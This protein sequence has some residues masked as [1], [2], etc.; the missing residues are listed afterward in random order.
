M[1][2]PFRTKLKPP[3]KVTHNTLFQSLYLTI[4]FFVSNDLLSYASACAFGFLFSFIPVV[5]LILVVLLR[6][7]HASP[8]TVINMMVNSELFSNVPN[9]EGLA[10]QI[11]SIEK[12]TNFEIVTVIAIV[13]M[14]RRFFSSVMSGLRCIFKN[15]VKARPMISQLFI[16]AGEAILIVLICVA[17]SLIIAFR[18]IQALPVFEG[19]IEKF[20]KLLGNSSKALVTWIPLAVIFIT[21]T[22]FYREGSGS[23]PPLG[24]TAFSALCSTAVF[25]AFQR[26]MNLFINV[27]RYNLVYGVLSNTIVLL[28]EVWFFFIF[29]LFF[30]EFLFVEQFLDTLVLSELYVLPDRDDISL[31]ASFKRIL[32]IHPDSL[33]VNPKNVIKC[34]KGSYIYQEGDEG[35]DV[36]YVIKG[37]VEI[38]RI[39]NISYLDKGAFFGET[40][41]LLN[42]IRI[43]SAKAETDVEI[44]RINEKDFFTIL[45]KNPAV[46]Q[47]ALSQISNYFSKFYGRSEQYPL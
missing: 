10:S 42:E 27:N 45:D 24:A 28:L 35:T 21:V 36:F 40:A 22:I 4:N 30:A 14:A 34:P 17:I 20:P 41:C 9:I 11:L 38:S 33:L 25:W 32:F 19:L 26:L 37:T 29:F 12:I 46:S 13:M 47:K 6:F 16:F 3:R 23:R 15:E 39:N 2:S 18:T 44:I 8:D 43:D 1:K 7:L 5:M 31:V